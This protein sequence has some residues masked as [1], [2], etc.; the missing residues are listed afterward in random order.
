M[1]KNTLEQSF[2]GGGT[3]VNSRDYHT[4]DIVALDYIKD[5]DL[6]VSGSIG[7]NP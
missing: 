4:D 5:L 1:N 6:A 2:L 7:K 3:Y